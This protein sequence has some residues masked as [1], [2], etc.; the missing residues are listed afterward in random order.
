[1]AYRYI[2][3][4]SEMAGDLMAARY[5]RTVGRLGAGE[6]RRFVGHAAGHLFLKSHAMS[7]EIYDAMCCRGFTGRPVS[8]TVMKLRSTDLLFILSNLMIVLILIA[9]EHLF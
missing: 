3:V 1:M 9:G 2:F 5:L 6:N 4:V 7:A 8:L